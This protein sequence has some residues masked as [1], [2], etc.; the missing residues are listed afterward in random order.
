V[1]EQEG[2]ESALAPPIAAQVAYISSQFME[3]RKIQIKFEPEDGGVGFMYA[4]GQ[5]LVRD[6]YL[7]RVRVAL[8]Q[9]GDP[10]QIVRQPDDPDQIVRVTRGIVLLRLRPAPDGV[11]PTVIDAVDTID[12]EFGIGIA[13]PDHVL[14]VAPEAG[15]CPATEP[16]EA[17]VDTEPYPGICHRSSGA[18]VL[19]FVADTGLLGGAARACPWLAGVAGDPDPLPSPDS[20]G[21][22]WIPPYCGHGTFVTGVV[23]CMAPE[24]QI[25]VANAFQVAGSTLES[26]LARRL[27]A[28]LD[29]GVDIFHLSITCTT[30]KNQPLIAIES[31]LHQLRQFKGAVCVVAAGNNGNRRRCW[32]AASEGTVSVGALG[33]DWR[34]RARFSNF[35][36]WVDVYAPGRDLV[37][38]FATGS[39]E[40]KVP[41]YARQV[42]KFNGMAR[43]SGT[44]FSTPIVTGLI[45]ARMSRSGENG[46][47][48]A[49][50]LLA[51]ARRLAIPGVGSILLPACDPP[52]NRDGCECPRYCRD[53]GQRG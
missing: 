15:P 2:G 13:T 45:A 25:Y 51:E 19:V 23:R 22:V 8:G 33:A 11:Q 41:P 50:A 3:K 53:S 42:R 44:S 37:N 16:E 14:T 46:Q 20:T 7:G 6:E 29:G 17:Y 21:T 43:W 12:R 48:A 38:A 5:I 36:S 30:W 34:S 40:C 52:C 27:S 28:A 31:W 47:Q 10:D 24:A 18:G 32:P 39:Y 4:E 26:D 9:P 35:G 49:A 1:S